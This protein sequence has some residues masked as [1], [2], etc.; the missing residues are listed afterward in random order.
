MDLIFEGRLS[1]QLSTRELLKRIAA[2]NSRGRTFLRFSNSSEALEGAILISDCRFVTAAGIFSGDDSGYSALRKLLALKDSHFA[3]LAASDHENTGLDASMSIDLDRLIKAHPDLPSEASELFNERALLDRVFESTTSSAEE[4][5][6]RE[7]QE[8]YV[9]GP[10]PARSSEHGWD[11]MQPLLDDESFPPGAVKLT[12]D[13][14]RALSSQ[15]RPS[16]GQ[17]ITTTRARA[18]QPLEQEAPPEKF[19]LKKIHII[20]IVAL[21]VIVILAMLL[22]FRSGH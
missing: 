21:I 20:A 15:K 6:P 18:L 1:D 19:A 13:D 5:R 22:I 11:L 2:R 14:V 16:S 3:V 8:I 10:P 9:E 7:S 17:Y 12:G 4:I